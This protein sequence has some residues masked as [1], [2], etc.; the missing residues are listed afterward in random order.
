MP[1]YHFEHAIQLSATQKAAIARAI[2]NWHATTFKAPQF[3][4]NCRFIDVSQGPFADNYIG[5]APRRINSLSV[6]LRSGAGRSQEQLQGMA[7]TLTGIWNDV[8]GQGS[9][10]Q[11]L[12]AM[13]IMG[14]VDSAKEAGFHL[15]LPGKFGQWVKDNADEFRRLAKAGDP[16]AIQVVEEMESRPEFRD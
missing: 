5:G 3:I 11:Q 7:D 13:Y 1:L 6:S 8:V 16:D 10:E 4:V 15:P 12:R 14:N 9:I 2:T